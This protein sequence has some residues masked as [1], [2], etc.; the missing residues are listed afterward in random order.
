MLIVS[1][2]RNA[3]LPSP[4]IGRTECQELK[5]LTK[6]TAWFGSKAKV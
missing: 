4:V 6:I 3:A 5:V 2:R 1:V